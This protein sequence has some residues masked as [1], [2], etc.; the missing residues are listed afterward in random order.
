VTARRKHSDPP[1]RPVDPGLGLVVDAQPDD[2]TCGAACLHGIYRHYGDDIALSQVAAELHRLDRGGTLDVFLANHALKRGYKVTLLTYNL[3][4]F[5]PTWFELPADEIRAKLEAQAA[6]KNWP[7]LQAATRGYDEF[8]GLGGTL[9]LRDL[10]PSLLR[11]YL[12]REI[13][14]I[15]GLSA[16]YLYRAVR[17]I[18]ETNEDDDVRGE[19]VGH[20][21]VLT[22][23]RKHPREVLIADPLQT[24]P[25]VGSRYYAVGAHRLIGAILLGAVTYDAN[26]VVVEPK[27]SGR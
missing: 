7:R 4:I 11:K 17:D 18:P 6:V 19:P 24:N 26:L 10:E 23:Y 13:P 22:G 15:T 14:V 9:E 1:A 12:K 25:L 21:V 3:E 20:F 27:S 8:L 5:D 2:E 16:T